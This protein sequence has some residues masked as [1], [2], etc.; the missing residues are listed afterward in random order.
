VKRR[1]SLLKMFDAA[2]DLHTSMREIGGVPTRVIENDGAGPVVVLLHGYSDQALTWVP[3]LRELALVGRR[4]VAVDLPGFGES[5]PLGPGPVLPQLDAFVAEA[6]AL[7]EEDGV[8]PVVAGNSLGGVLAIRAGS[9]PDLSLSAIVPISPAGYGHSRWIQWVERA[10]R[11]MGLAN[12][13]ILPMVIYRPV[14]RHAFRI[15]GSGHGAMVE[16]AA[17]TY[18]RQYRRR[19]DVRRLLGNGSLVLSEARESARST[20]PAVPMLIVWGKRDRLTLHSGSERLLKQVANAELAELVTLPDC[21]HCP[22]LEEPQL[23][24]EVLD[25]YIERLGAKPRVAPITRQWM[26]R[27]GA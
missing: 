8:P 4:A 18:S 22:Q 5:E 26:R 20:T 3:L 13:A 11:L 24:A 21:G 16:D 7:Y 14:A 10:P 1:K 6:A 25:E 15:L 27:A 9:D 23:V 17:R 12:R 2:P 19:S